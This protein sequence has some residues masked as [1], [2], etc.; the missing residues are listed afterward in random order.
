[1]TGRFVD[2]QIEVP[3]TRLISGLFSGVVER[4][5]DEM[6]LVRGD[7]GFVEVYAHGATLIARAYRFGDDGAAAAR[8]ESAWRAWME[9]HVT[10]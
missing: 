9:E 7:D 3:G 10:A 1:M 8:E 6:V 4:T 2:V 5:L